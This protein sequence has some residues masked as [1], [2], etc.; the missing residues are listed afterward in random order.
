MTGASLIFRLFQ[1][2][3]F[4]DMLPSINHLASQGSY[5]AF[6]DSNNFLEDTLGAVIEL[7]IGLYRGHDVNAYKARYLS[8]VEKTVRAERVGSGSWAAI[9]YLYPSAFTIV[10]L[11]ILLKRRDPRL[12]SDA[13]ASK[14]N[15]FC[16]EKMNG[17]PR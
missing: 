9:I 6:G 10:F 5:T 14:K 16:K 17:S 2:F 15:A 12:F 8:P 1:Q 13:R 7:G 3:S 11:L 4:V